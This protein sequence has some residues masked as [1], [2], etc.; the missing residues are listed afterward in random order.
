MRYRLA[1]KFMAK[2]QKNVLTACAISMIII[3]DTTQSINSLW[4]ISIIWETEQFK[5]GIKT[6]LTD[7]ASFL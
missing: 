7:E 1:A 5:S 4:Y 6:K 3:C 2:V